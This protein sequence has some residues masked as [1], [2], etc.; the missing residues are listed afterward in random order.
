MTIF[1]NKNSFYVLIHFCFIESLSIP[2][3]CVVYV[4]VILQVCRGTQK[5]DKRWIRRSIILPTWP[6][7]YSGCHSPAAVSEGLST[8][9]GNLDE[10]FLM[11]R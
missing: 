8:L 3:R 2:G 5:I 6:C 7:H 4:D 10:T 11:F 9:P 1:N